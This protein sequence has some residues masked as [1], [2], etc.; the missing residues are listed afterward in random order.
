LTIA[1]TN[2]AAQDSGSAPAPAQT[3]RRVP[4]SNPEALVDRSA[5]SAAETYLERR[6]GVNPAAA[7]R[8]VELSALIGQLKRRLIEQKELGFSSLWVEHAPAYK[9]M[10][11]FAGGGRDRAALLQSIDPKLRGFIQFKDVRRTRE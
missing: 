10:L 9:I 7:R 1:S 11:G 6:F 5:P 2:G 3:E 8:H 4:P